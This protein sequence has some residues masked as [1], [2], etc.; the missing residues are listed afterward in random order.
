MVDAR[1]AVAPAVDRRSGIELFGA[2]S[3]ERRGRR[4][5]ARAGATSEFGS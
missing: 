2:R 4:A 1:I 5:S 3:V